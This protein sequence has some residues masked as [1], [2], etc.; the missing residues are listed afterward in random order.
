MID[1]V[2]IIAAPGAESP[3]SPMNLSLMI[4][5]QEADVL[6]KLGKPNSVKAVEPVES[7]A[8]LWT[9]RRTIDSV[10][11]SVPT[12]MAEVPKFDPYSEGFKM[13]REPVYSTRIQNVEEVT[14][15]VMVNGRFTNFERFV[16]RP[17]VIDF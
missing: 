3:L 13:V 11:Q 4:G 15:L 7:K 2:E 1:G 14:I 8:E 12:G 16:E 10:A 6:L 17:P 5:L 9:Y